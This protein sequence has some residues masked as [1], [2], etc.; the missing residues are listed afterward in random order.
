MT[1][2]FGPLE[3]QGE[4]QLINIRELGYDR[5]FFIQPNHQ[6]VNLV[7]AE[8]SLQ[9]IHVRRILLRASLNT[10]TVTCHFLSDTDLASALANFSFNA[11]QFFLEL[12]DADGQSRLKLLPREL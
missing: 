9:F 1:I 4:F 11:A 3:A 5:D 8:F 6:V 10:D 2:V 12:S 7:R